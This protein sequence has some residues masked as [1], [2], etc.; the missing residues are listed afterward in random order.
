MLVKRLE[1]KGKMANKLL[2]VCVVNEPQILEICIVTPWKQGKH[3]ESTPHFS[4]QSTFIA[5]SMRGLHFLFIGAEL[6]SL[7]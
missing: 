1:E 6:S 7:P 4:I 2:K 5:A 3:F